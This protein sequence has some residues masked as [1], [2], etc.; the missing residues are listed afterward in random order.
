MTMVHDTISVVE[1]GFKTDLMMAY[2]NVQ[3]GL[4]LLQYGTEKCY[5]IHVGL[6]KEKYKC[7]PVY[8]DGWEAKDV[9]CLQTGQIRL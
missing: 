3:S 6:Y 9:D 8:M 1:C 5:K 7:S 2:L 4:K